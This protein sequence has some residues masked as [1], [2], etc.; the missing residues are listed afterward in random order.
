[1]Q[2]DSTANEHRSIHD[3]V[4]EQLQADAPPTPWRQR[5]LDELAARKQRGR[6]DFCK[7]WDVS[8]PYQATTRS[9]AALREWSEVL[10]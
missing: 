7:H 6:R 2:P 4:R 8:E 3:V 10:Q 5:V 1:M 9:E